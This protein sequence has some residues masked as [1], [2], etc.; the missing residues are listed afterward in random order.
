MPANPHN[1]LIGLTRESDVFRIQSQAS[2]KARRLRISTSYLVHAC[3]DLEQSNQGLVFDLGYLKSV[4]G[5]ILTW[6][7]EE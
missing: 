1:Y 2:D 3:L 6:F 5:L 7:S 4:L